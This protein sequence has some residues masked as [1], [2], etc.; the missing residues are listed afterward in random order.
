M[1]AGANEF[2]AELPLGYDTAIEERGATSWADD[3]NRL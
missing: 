3:D 1:F 2:V